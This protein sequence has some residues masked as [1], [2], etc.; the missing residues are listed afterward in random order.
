[1]VILLFLC[2]GIGMVIL[3]HRCRER[4][5]VVPLSGARDAYLAHFNPAFAGSQAPD[6]KVVRG[7]TLCR[8]S[9]L[10]KH[11]HKEAIVEKQVKVLSVIQGILVDAQ[12]KTK[13]SREAQMYLIGL[14]KALL[15]E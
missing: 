4:G 14:R 13:L 11:P 8:G 10:Y 1:M 9:H 12:S 6:G 7:V 5:M 2:R 3:S 15:K